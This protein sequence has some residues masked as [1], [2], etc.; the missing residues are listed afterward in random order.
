MSLC[1]SR[2]SQMVIFPIQSQIQPI[3][4]LE[5][6]QPIQSIQPIQPILQTNKQASKQTNEFHVLLLQL[7]ERVNYLENIISKIT[8]SMN[9]SNKCLKKAIKNTNYVR[10]SKIKTK[11]TLSNLKK[12]VD[13]CNSVSSLKNGSFK[14]RKLGKSL[15]KYKRSKRSHSTKRYK[16]KL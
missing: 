2:K 5:P 8:N 12:I 16:S 7:Q 11:H 15:T 9:T 4:S 13:N 3:Q 10:K 6:L 14:K 1:T